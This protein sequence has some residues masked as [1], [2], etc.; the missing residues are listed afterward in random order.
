MKRNLFDISAQIFIPFFTIA[1]YLA[2]SFKLPQWGLILNLAAQPFWIYSTWKAYKNAGQI[3]I[4][5]NTVILTM[6]IAFG[7]VNY[8]FM[9][10]V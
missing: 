7:V 3:G 6:I 8:W 1:G 4:L 2:I 10:K 9:G 5:I